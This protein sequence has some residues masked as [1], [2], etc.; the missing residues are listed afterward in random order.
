MAK[1]RRIDF[2]AASRYQT[3][4]ELIGVKNALN[5]VFNSPE[6]FVYDLDGGFF[7]EFFRNGVKQELGKQFVIL[8]SSGNGIG[9]RMF[10]PPRPNESLTI[11]YVRI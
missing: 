8:L 5:S 3:G 11:N 1:S 10:R 7:F 9:V 4:E 6:P 2:I